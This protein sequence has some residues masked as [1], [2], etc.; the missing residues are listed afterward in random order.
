MFDIP[1]HNSLCLA[2]AAAA[3]M[4][5][6]LDTNSWYIDVGEVEREPLPTMQSVFNQVYNKSSKTD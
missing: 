2:V 3:Y 5:K 4:E 6:I 1:P